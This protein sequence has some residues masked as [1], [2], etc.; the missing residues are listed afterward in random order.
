MWRNLANLAGE[1]LR[2]AD[3]ELA[4]DDEREQ[5]V[6]S[7]RFVDRRERSRVAFADAAVHDGLLDRRR[8]VQEPQRVGNRRPRA[9]DAAGHLFLR[10]PELVDQSAEGPCLVHRVEVGSLQVLDQRQPELLLLVRGPHD[11]RGCASSPASLAARSRRSP[12]ISW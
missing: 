4:S 7:G 1:A 9:A 12:A 8:R 10:Q 2:V 3:G 11:A 6:L 5:L